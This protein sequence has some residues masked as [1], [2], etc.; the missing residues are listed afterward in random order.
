[1]LR[2]CESKTYTDNFSSKERE[3]TVI[4]KQSLLPMKCG[5]NYENTG[6]IFLEF[7]VYK[8]QFQMVSKDSWSTVIYAVTVDE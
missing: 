7:R 2:N 6:I 3:E 5:Y 8:I 1:M 4:S